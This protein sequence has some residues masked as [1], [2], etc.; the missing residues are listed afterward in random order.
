MGTGTFYCSTSKRFNNGNECSGREKFFLS[1]CRS[2]P[3]DTQ[4]SLHT[5]SYR[6][7]EKVKTELAERFASKIVLFLEG[8][9]SWH[10]GPSCQDLLALGWR[11]VRG[12]NQN[13]KHSVG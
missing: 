6:A 10:N 5:Q 9:V 1:M 4:A 7:L 8:K 13:E 12:R 2:L 11:G 3:E